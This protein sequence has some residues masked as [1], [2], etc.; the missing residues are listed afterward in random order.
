M[1]SP[2]QEHGPPQDPTNPEL[3]IFGILIPVRLGCIPGE[4]DRPQDVEFD[5]AIR[6]ATPPKGMVTDQIEDTISYIDIVDR[7]KGVITGNEFALI[8]FLGRELFAA[9][10]TLLDEGDR[11]TLTVRKLTPPVPEIRRGAEFILSD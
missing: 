9:I 5:V 3:R 10:R 8:E 4:R 6:F 11:L 2:E 7:L 1:A